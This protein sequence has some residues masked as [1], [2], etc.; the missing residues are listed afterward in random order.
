M[1]IDDNY[2]TGKNKYKFC[3][4][5]FSQSKTLSYAGS[6]GIYDCLEICT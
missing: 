3:I 6:T 4:L 2:I 5:S 1:Q